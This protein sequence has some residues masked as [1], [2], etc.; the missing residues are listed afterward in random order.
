MLSGDTVKKGLGMLAA[1][2]LALLIISWVFSFWDLDRIISARFYK[3]GTGW[4]L[5][6]AEPWM[7]LYRYGTIPGIVLSITALVGAVITR[8]RNPDSCWHRYFLLVVLTSVIGAG[9]LVNGIL[10]PYWGRPRPNQIIELGGQYEYR[11]VLSPGIPGKGKS[12][13]SGHA[14]MG[15]LFVSIVYFRR[16]SAAVA[17]IGGIGGLAYG[18][19][20]S[21][22]RVVQGAHFTTDCIWSLGAI[23]ITASV[24]YYFI[25]RIPAPEPEKPHH[26]TRKQKIVLGVFGTLVSA[27]I[28]LVLLARQPFYETY[29]FHLS[30]IDPT[31]RELR[32]GLKNG[33][34]RAHVRYNE[35]HPPLVLIHARGFAWT[36]ASETPG[37]VSAKISENVYQAVYVMQKQ[38]YFAE[39]THD[40]E[41]VLPGRYKDK[42]NVV[43]MDDTGKP[44][45]Q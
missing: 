4:Y 15:F 36:G 19:L 39:L 34:V 25:L 24:L 3:P 9:L 2:I 43:F 44:L 32:I 45:P 8:L 31:I 12:F 5:K 42:L 21:A 6:E 37:K 22:A 16:K 38:G 30:P 13:P 23:W 14:T 17:W 40:I 28:I 26:L 41:V 29:Y 20:M 35:I 10:K 7:W 18:A 33:F 11:N 27:A 1:T